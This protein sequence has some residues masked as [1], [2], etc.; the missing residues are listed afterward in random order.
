VVTWI[1]GTPFSR[2]N[3]KANCD[4]N[5][6]QL[7]AYNSVLFR[8]SL[9]NCIPHWYICSISRSCI[10]KEKLLVYWAE[11]NWNSNPLCPVHKVFCNISTS[12]R[13]PK[14]P[15]PVP[16]S[17]WNFVFIFISRVRFSCPTCPTVLQF[18]FHQY[19]LTSTNHADAH[20]AILFIPLLF[21]LSLY[22]I[23]PSASGPAD[24][25]KCLTLWNTNT[26]QY[27]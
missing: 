9:K 13:P 5:N 21:P 24:Y 4:R 7:T 2:T 3:T 11:G 20:C 26:H 15:L 27:T 1:V 6:G 22:Q 8:K 16:V 17:N 23:S 25:F 14:L 12:P 19:S 10:A 18:T